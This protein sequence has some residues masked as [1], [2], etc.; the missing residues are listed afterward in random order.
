MFMSR[1]QTE[2]TKFMFRQKSVDDSSCLTKIILNS[3]ILKK[4]VE[5]QPYN[6]I[7]QSAC[8]F[9]GYQQF[10]AKKRTSENDKIKYNQLKKILFNW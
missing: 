2:L 1:P 5:S 10:A 3:E 7:L 9:I 6:D 4:K 8:I